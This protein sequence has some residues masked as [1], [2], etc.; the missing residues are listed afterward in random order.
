MVFKVPDYKIE[1]CVWFLDQSDKLHFGKI[2][3]FTLCVTNEKTNIYYGIES[4]DEMNF[5]IMESDII[6]HN[7]QM[8]IPKYEAGDYISYKFIT[9]NKEEVTTAGKI[10]RVELTIYDRNTAEVVY[11]MDDDS[12]YWVLEDDIIGHTEKNK[13]AFVSQVE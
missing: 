13:D 6:P 2:K 7:R 10:D 3:M 12:D 9:T 8:P 4:N 5:T 1:D 11:I